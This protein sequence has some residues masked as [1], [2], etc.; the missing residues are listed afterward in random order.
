[1]I[2]EV[3]PNRAGLGL[4]N[5]VKFEMSKKQDKKQYLLRITRQRFQ[6]A[7]IFAIDD[8]QSDAM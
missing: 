1:M 7:E 8:D 2:N 5:E 4:N 3:R 6:K